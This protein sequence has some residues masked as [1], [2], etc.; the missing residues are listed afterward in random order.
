M[1]LELVFFHT[2]DGIRFL[3]RSRGLGD[4]YKSQLTPRPYLCTPNMYV[5]LCTC[6]LNTSDAAD[7]L[8]RF[9]FA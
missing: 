1:A 9:Y 3:V 8:K 6:L 4:G 5:P 2:E 7:D